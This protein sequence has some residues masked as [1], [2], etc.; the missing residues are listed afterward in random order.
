[1]SFVVGD[2]V[3]V[4]H[5]RKVESHLPSQ[6]GREQYKKG[7]KGQ[8]FKIGA[9]RTPN[10]FGDC[11]ELTA[12]RGTTLDWFFHSDEIKRVEI[13]EPSK[14][15]VGDYVRVFGQDQPVRVTRVSFCVDVVDANGCEN[16]AL[17]PLKVCSKEEMDALD[18]AR[19]EKEQKAMVDQYDAKLDTMKKL[20]DE[21]VALRKKMDDAAK[22]TEMKKKKNCC[23]E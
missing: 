21:M 7:K 9:I 5:V 22:E 1:M 16:R 6:Q 23:S 15:A 11:Y 17:V 2:V 18:T 19:L 20:C 13:V 14:V 8:M 10:A 4:V 12:G 3:E